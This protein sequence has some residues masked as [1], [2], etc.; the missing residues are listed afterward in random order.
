MDDSWLPTFWAALIAFALFVYIVCDGYDLGVGILFGFTRDRAL[1]DTMVKA[2][3]PF[4]D[5]NEVWLVLVGASLFG[6]FPVVY[7]ILLSA[8]YLPVTLMLLA[9]IFRGVSFEFRYLSKNN[10]LWDRGFFLGS[11]VTSFVQGMVAGG[12][13]QQLPVAGGQYAGVAFDWL[14]PFSLLCGAFLTI[15]YALLG[16]AWLVLKTEGELRNRSYRGLARLLLGALA[17]LALVC[18]WTFTDQPRVANRWRE[19]GWLIIFPLS[20]MLASLGLWAG[21]RK[22]IDGIPYAMAVVLF[23]TILLAYA[24]S[25]WPHLVPFTVTIEAA[26]APIQTLRFLFYGAGIVVFPLVLFYTG[27]VYWVLRGKV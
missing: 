3:S 1:R 15:G 24:G 23:L 20:G 5:G 17:V 11:L 8:F 18:I 19:M 21:I 10:P 14:T 2:I 26:A 16:A 9:L 12:L 6:A 4:W 22:R 25:F 13:V 7:A 27:V